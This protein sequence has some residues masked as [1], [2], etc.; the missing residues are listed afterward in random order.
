MT[1]IRQPPSSLTVSPTRARFSSHNDDEAALEQRVDRAVARIF[2][3]L[4]RR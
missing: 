2:E 3:R 1:L 4:R